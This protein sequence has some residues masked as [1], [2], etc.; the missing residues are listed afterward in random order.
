MKCVIILFLFLEVMIISCLVL[1][2][3]V[4]VVISLILGVLMMG[5]SFLGI[6][7]VVGRKCVFRL[8]VGMIVVNGVSIFGCDIV[9]M[10]ICS[11]LIV[12]FFVGV[13]LVFV[14]DGWGC[15]IVEDMVIVSKL[16]LC[17]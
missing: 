14:W 15:V 11:V 8:V 5:S 6:V 16:V 13:V 9:Y 1:V 3:V 10:I 4:L 7:L 17:D 2:V 12:C